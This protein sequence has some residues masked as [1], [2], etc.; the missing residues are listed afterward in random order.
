MVASG[1]KLSLAGRRGLFGLALVLAGPVQGATSPPPW[2]A[3]LEPG[4]WSAISQNTMADVDPA[5]DPGLNP[6]FPGSAPWRANS[7]QR[8]VITAWNGGALAERYGTH[9]ALLTFGGGHNSYHGSEVYAFDLA[10]R[11]WRRASDPYTGPISFPYASTAYPDGS[12]LPAHTYDYVDYHPGT[13]SFVLMRGLKDGRLSTNET[14]TAIVHLLDLGTGQWRR[15]RPNGSLRM[16][17][18]G[19]SCY[20]RVRD[21]FWILGAPSTTNQ[22]TKF[23]PKVV[24]GDGT[25]G[26]FTNYAPP[27]LE[28]D[29]GADCDPVNDLFVYTLFRGSDQVF[30]VD[31]KQP[32]SPRVPLRESGDA[33]DKL[34]ANGWAWS[35]KRQAFI[36]WRAGAGVYEFKLVE[37]AWDTGTWRWTNL[38]SSV[39]TVEPEAMLTNNGVY[40]RF[41]IARW[42]DEEVA[43]VVNRHDGPVYAYR[44]PAVAPSAVRPLVSLQSTP[45]RVAPGASAS[46]VWS[47]QNATSCSA[48]AGWSGNRPVSGQQ[49]TG[50]L[51]STTLYELEC[52]NGTGAVGRAS[53]EVAVTDSA[54]GQPPANA[55]PDIAGSPPSTVVAGT[56]YVFEPSASD[57]EDDPLAFTIQNRPSWLQFDA[58]TGRL[59]GTP[60]DA[61]VGDFANI[62][63]SVSDGA[64]SATLPGFAIR[65]MERGLFSGEVSWTPPTQDADGDPLNDLAGYTVYIGSSPGSYYRSVRVPSAVQTN[66][67]VSGLT[68]GE[69]FF[70]VSSFDESGNESPPSM[71]VRAVLGSTSGG[72]PGGGDGGDQGGEPGPGPVVASGG[73]SGAV[74]EGFLLLLLG[75]ARRLTRTTARKA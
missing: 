11:T 35:D 53:V 74:A 12:P 66:Y 48:A 58:T 37:G 36:Y 46:L 33:P 73:G 8:G 18:G 54:G 42:G 1:S 30:A 31:L 43:L 16:H 28:I 19:L 51:S 56:A 38:T 27:R 20:D 59:S 47:A 57:A 69:Y 22:F 32:G 15:S 64:A 5:S 13:N 40:S 17:S 71:P 70:A 62:V 26:E 44:I 60:S 21:V 2:V 6:A 39:N 25:V 4:T 45:Q 49:S 24:N 55:A 68:A 50:P 29:G 63:I 67:L 75:V 65:V 3:A 61:N 34:S 52:V 41:R 10:S 9:G 14:G 7:G 72:S 23:D